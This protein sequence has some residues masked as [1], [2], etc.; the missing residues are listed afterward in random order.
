MLHTMPH[1]STY[2][3]SQGQQNLQKYMSHLHNVGTWSMTQS[4]IPLRTHKHCVPP[5]TIKLTGSLVHRT[6][7]SLAM[8]DMINWWG[9]NHFLWLTNIFYSHKQQSVWILYFCT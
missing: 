9:S 8:V 4:N 6:Y 3:C 1:D 2:D 7:A 5:Y